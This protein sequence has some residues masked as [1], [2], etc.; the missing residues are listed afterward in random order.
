MHHATGAGRN[1]ITSILCVNDDDGFRC[2]SRHCFRQSSSHSC[3]HVARQHVRIQTM[4]HKSLCDAFQSESSAATPS[5]HAHTRSWP[6][7]VIMSPNNIIKCHYY[8]SVEVLCRYFESFWP[9]TVPWSNFLP[10]Q[11]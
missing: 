8:Q 7:V 5:R 2:A 10:Q 11:H 3:L 9:M 1:I 4:E 6:G